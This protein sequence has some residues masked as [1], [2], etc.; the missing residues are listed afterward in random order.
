MDRNNR[1]N[2]ETKEYYDSAQI[3]YNL[4]WSDRALHYGF[5]EDGTKDLS[6]AIENTNRFV[7]KLLNLQKK[8]YV[9]DA[10]C[11]TGGSSIFMAEN[12]GV[13]LIGVTLSPIQIKQ[14]RKNAGKL[15]L[16]NLINFKLMDFNK[17]E[18]ENE[19]FT[20]IFGIESVCH[21]DNKSHFL[22]EAYRIL[23]PGGRIVIADGFLIRNN[24]TKKEKEIY[25]KCLKGWKVANLSNKADFWDDLIK[26]G[27]KNIRFYDKTDEIIPSSNRIALYGSLFF[28]ISLVLSK[29]RLISKSL[30]ENSICM[31][32][33]K[34]TFGN[35]TIYGVFV[36][37][38]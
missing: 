24:L 12:F 32:N 5:W 18:F 35:F 9:L 36:A 1:V 14:A 33:Q 2:E 27:F 13:K 3:L 6:E 15:K 37:E 20:K 23:E 26:T 8:D 30:H 19:T 25:N 16:D 29:A 4:F 38:K 22:R 7:S 10:G 11:G 34:K 28:P 17:M 21:A 31:I